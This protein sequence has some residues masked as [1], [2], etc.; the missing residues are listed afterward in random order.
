[1]TVVDLEGDGLCE[2]GRR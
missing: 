2:G 1:M